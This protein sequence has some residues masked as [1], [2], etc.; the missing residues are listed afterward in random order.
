MQLPF[1]GFD[2]KRGSDREVRVWAHVTVCYSLLE[3]NRAWRSCG[4][5]F[6]LLL[7]FL[8]WSRHSMRTITVSTQ[9]TWLLTLRLIGAGIHFTSMYATPKSR[10]SFY[11]QQLM[12]C[13]CTNMFEVFLY[14]HH[15]EVC[16]KYEIFSSRRC[17]QSLSISVCVNRAEF[18]SSGKTFHI[19]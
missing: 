8:L 5:F 14:F 6:S 2:L 11:D 19:N 13:F 15:S 9:I 1:L 12:S 4:L 10:Y 17:Y 16:L 3:F 18:G 7:C